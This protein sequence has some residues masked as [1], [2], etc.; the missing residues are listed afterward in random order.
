MDPRGASHE[1]EGE[2]VTVAPFVDR[3]FQT[4]Q[5]MIKENRDYTEAQAAA[6]RKQVLSGSP[7]TECYGGKTGDRSWLNVGARS[8]LRSC[9]GKRWPLTP[10][11]NRQYRRACLATITTWVADQETRNLG[12]KGQ[13]TRISGHN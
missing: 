3:T 4:L 8:Y 11:C 10:V 6:V 2:P 7:G 9:N 5:Q 1:F 12:S 13:E